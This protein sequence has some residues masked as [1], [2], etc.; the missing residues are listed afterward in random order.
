[1]KFTTSENE[2]IDNYAD[3]FSDLED[4]HVYE[5]T[6]EEECTEV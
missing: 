6:P 4:L 1:M 5:D 2:Y 3:Y